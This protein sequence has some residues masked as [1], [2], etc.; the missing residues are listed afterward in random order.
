MADH[1]ISISERTYNGLLKEIQANKTT[2]DAWIASKLTTFV[3]QPHDPSNQSEA[4]ASPSINGQK[5]TEDNAVVQ[6]SSAQT[7]VEKQARPLSELLAEAGLFDETI[8]YEKTDNKPRPS[9][10]DDPFGDAL[11]ADMERQG[12]H[13][14]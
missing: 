11:I 14:S 1:T 12:I 13:I 4:L 3:E 2:V 9:A 8:D 5:E 6:N 7:I 10:T